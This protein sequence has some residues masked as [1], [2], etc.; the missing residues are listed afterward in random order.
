MAMMRDF[1]YSVIS[2]FTF[3]FIS[4]ILC[5]SILNTVRVVISEPLM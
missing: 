1:I 5:S 4:V 2:E 3:K